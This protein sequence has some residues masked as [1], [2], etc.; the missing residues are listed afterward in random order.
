MHHVRTNDSGRS[1]RDRGII[2][3]LT[4]K[5]LVSFYATNFRLEWQV[6]LSEVDTVDAEAGGFL[7][8]NKRGRRYDQFLGIDHGGFKELFHRDIEKS[9]N[10]LVL[11]SLLTLSTRCSVLRDLNASRRIKE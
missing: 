7:I 2:A 3:L 11:R 10:P 4:T 6:I 5:R 1:E 9:V 8:R